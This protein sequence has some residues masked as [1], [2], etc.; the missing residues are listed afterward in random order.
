[1]RTVLA[2]A[3]VWLACAGSCGAARFIA[4]SDPHLDPTADPSLVPALMAADAADWGPILERDQTGF[5]QFGRDSTWLLVRSALDQMRSVEPDPA[6]LLL[7]GDL[8]VHRFRAKFDTVAPGRDDADYDAFVAKTI[9]FLVAQVMARFPGKPVYLALGN[10]DDFCGD[11]GVEPTGAFLAATE[12]TAL[13]LLGEAADANAF[14]RAWD[15]GFGYDVPNRAIAGLR[16]IFLNSILFS[17][18]YAPCTPTAGHDPG[19]AALDWL[20]GR[21]AEARQAKEKVWLIVHIPPGGDAFATYGRGGCDGIVSMWTGA[22]TDRFLQLVRGNGDLI[23]AIFAGHTHMDEFRLLGD[24]DHPDGL[25]LGT[26]GISPLFA[27]NPG[28]HVYDV[29]ASGQLL[30]R[31]TWALKNLPLVGPGVAPDWRAEY[32]FDQLWGLPGLDPPG[33]AAL[34]GR[35]ATD[36]ATRRNW[37]SVYRVGREAAWGISGGVQALPPEEFAAYH[38][39]ITAVAVDAYRCCVCG[40]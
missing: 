18:K 28:F 27:Q 17:P 26:P 34:A 36:P 21:L 8:V 1:M 16:M 4:F 33:L 39:A 9:E 14:A 40:G 15:A 24:P 30:D 38:C 10:N 23:G 3:L 29:G 7:T 35:I 20:A 2:A 31:Q 11:Y 5:G 25:V 13:A 37:F 6:F 22:T 19:G 12:R 32:R